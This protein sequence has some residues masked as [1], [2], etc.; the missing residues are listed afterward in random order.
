MNTHI[1]DSWHL[2]H[3]PQTRLNLRD[4]EDLKYVAKFSLGVLVGTLL[5][6]AAVNVV[7]DLGMPLLPTIG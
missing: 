7:F 1:F 5:F 4:K 3:M 6:I 2:P